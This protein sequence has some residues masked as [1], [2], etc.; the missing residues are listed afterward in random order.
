MSFSHTP[1][2]LNEVLDLLSLKEGMCCFDGTL[3]GAGHARAAAQRL[4]KT[5]T[6]I[7]CDLDPEALAAAE[8][9]LSDSPAKT[10]FFHENFKDC[11]RFLKQAG[12]SQIDA[13]LL[14]LGVS[15]HQLDEASRGFSYH[16]DAPL[17]MRLSGEGRSAADVVNTETEARLCEI[18]F[19]Y[20]EEKNAAAIA[21]SIVRARA[22]KP[23]ETTTELVECVKDAFHG[24]FTDKHPARRTFQAL[25]I[26]VNGELDRLD[27]A[28]RDLVDLLTPGG[29]LCVISFH[30]L[31]DRIV[32][33]CFHSLIDGCTCPKDFPVCICGFEPSVRLLT[34]RPVTA[35]EREL[36]ENPR[37]R[38]AK[39]R[40]VQKL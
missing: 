34:R 5:G 9:A 23:I 11:A 22:I 1:V 24:R 14:D 33:Q 19:R 21:A 39:L 40:A 31:E 17:D 35:G 16:A 8:E 28:I 3:G 10:V 4:G 20:G 2:L 32:K 27:D 15:S 7:G 36:E 6:L 18:L 25:R 13:A 12:Y 37:A 26:E 30:S 38:S 29:V